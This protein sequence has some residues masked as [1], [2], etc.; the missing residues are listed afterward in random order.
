MTSSV[1]DH[2]RWLEWQQD[3]TMLGGSRR[4]VL[5]LQ[6]A[7]IN[8]GD[9]QWKI[10][11]K[12]QKGVHDSRIPDGDHD[13]STTCRWRTM[14]SCTWM[15]VS[16]ERW[17]SAISMRDGNQRATVEDAQQDMEG[18]VPRQTIWRCPDSGTI[19]WRAGMIIGSRRAHHQ[20]KKS[21]SWRSGHLA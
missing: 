7:D 20:K 12:Q 10:F 14:T 4:A 15:A 18:A 5:S 21:N 9:P 8:K 3:M 19:P 2:N 16:H 13:E 1:K 11:H 6:L 17:C